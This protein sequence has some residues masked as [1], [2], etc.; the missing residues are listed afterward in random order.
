MVIVYKTLWVAGS[1]SEILTLHKTIANVEPRHLISHYSESEST[2]TRRLNQI[3][4][5]FPLPNKK[6]LLLIA[7]ASN[8]TKSHQSSPMTSLRFFELLYFMPSFAIFK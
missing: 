8:S 3:T 7:L 2:N 4:K 1:F 5:Q 6:G